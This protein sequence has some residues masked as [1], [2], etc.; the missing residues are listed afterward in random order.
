MD[1]QNLFEIQRKLNEHI[2]DTHQLQGRD[3]LPE[4]F[5]ALE[6]ELGELANETRC[7]KYWSL[8]KA[9]DPKVILEEYVDCLH[10]ILSLGLMMGYRHLSLEIPEGKG[11]LTQQFLS[12]FEAIDTLRKTRQEQEFLH[13]WR[14]F[15]VLGHS[16]GFSLE[17]IEAGY[18]EKNQINHQ[19]QAEGY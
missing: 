5:L 12:L 14:S 13:L 17:T 6:V 11:T 19:R 1:L 9:S 7:F 3:L 15:L 16:L 10:F 4:V 2:V 8:K 18:L